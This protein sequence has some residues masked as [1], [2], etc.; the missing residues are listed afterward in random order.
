[1]F[2]IFCLHPYINLGLKLLPLGV[3][4]FSKK[5]PYRVLE[6]IDFNDNL[7]NLFKVAQQ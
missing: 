6:G 4:I 2:L 5:I 7:K 1:M 3:E